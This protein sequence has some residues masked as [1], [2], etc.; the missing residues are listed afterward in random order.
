MEAEYEGKKTET[1]EKKWKFHKN[2]FAKQTKE[3][4]SFYSVR[5]HSI[6]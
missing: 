6:L 1:N 5:V 3:I 2:F 4:I